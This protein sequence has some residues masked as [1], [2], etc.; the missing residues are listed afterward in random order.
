MNIQFVAVG[1]KSY[2][3]SVCYGEVSIS[4]CVRFEVLVVAFSCGFL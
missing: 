2:V 1:N 4:G 3:R